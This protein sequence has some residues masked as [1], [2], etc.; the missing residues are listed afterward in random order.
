MT[1]WLE[2]KIG[3]SKVHWL[4]C[5]L[6]TNELMKRKLNEHLGKTTIGKTG[7]SGQGN[8]LSKDKKP[9][10]K[11]PGSSGLISWFGPGSYLSITYLTG[12]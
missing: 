6:H 7:F 9:S 4:I 3:G 5:Q 12:Q 10:F 11:E 2:W 1:A 8:M